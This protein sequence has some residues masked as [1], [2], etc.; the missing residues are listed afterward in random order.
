VEWEKTVGRAKNEG[1]VVVSVPARTELRKATGEMF[2]KRFGIEVEM[3]TGRA[4]TIVRE[5]HRWN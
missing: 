2:R 1:K 3:I 5:N 4:A